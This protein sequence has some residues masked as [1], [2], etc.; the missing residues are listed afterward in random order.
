[1]NDAALAAVRTIAA[2]IKLDR[3]P[4]T[5]FTAWVRSQDDVPELA[6]AIVENGVKLL[7]RRAQARDA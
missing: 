1:M 5:R 3:V 7:A 6:R 2:K 4:L